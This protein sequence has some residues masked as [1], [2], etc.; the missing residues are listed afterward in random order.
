[1]IACM[2][3]KISYGG[4]LRLR[5]GYPSTCML[6]GRCC[7]EGR[8]GATDKENCHCHSFGTQ[9]F[10]HMIYYNFGHCW[11]ASLKMEIGFFHSD[12][13]KK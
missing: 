8:N 4:L 12:T 10:R 5:T 6:S 2:D 9:R 3:E 11:N 1:M 7:T 13:F